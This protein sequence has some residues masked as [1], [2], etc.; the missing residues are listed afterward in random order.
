MEESCDAR[1]NIT[2]KTV[3][4]MLKNA[5]IGKHTRFKFK[6]Y[7]ELEISLGKLT[8]TSQLVAIIG[9]HVLG[10]TGTAGIYP[11]I[12]NIWATIWKI[13]KKESQSVKKCRQWETN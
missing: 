7:F 1:G 8:G 11:L 5:D 3:I 6:R 9:T 12:G 2:A 13:T 10:L 4:K